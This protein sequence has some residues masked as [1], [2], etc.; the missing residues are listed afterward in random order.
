MRDIDAALDGNNQAI[1]ELLKR[2][3]DF[4]RGSPDGQYDEVAVQCINYA[5]HMQPWKTIPIQRFVFNG[6]RRDGK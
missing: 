3:L 6:L 2:A 1:E 5:L 4:Y